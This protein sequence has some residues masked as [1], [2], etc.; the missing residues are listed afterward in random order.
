MTTDIYTG[1]TGRA[2]GTYDLLT[3]LENQ[4][5]LGR[6]QTHESI[7]AF[8][9]QIIG[10]DG[11]T[12]ILATTPVR[13]EL[14]VSNPHDLDIDYWQTISDETA[15]SIR[16]AFAAVYDSGALADEQA[17]RDYEQ[18]LAEGRRV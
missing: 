12:V 7:G 2:I 4:Y 1:K 11:D 14:L 15:D 8:L 6:T 9:D 3:E 18:A 16:E 10:I 13:P 5:G 17:E